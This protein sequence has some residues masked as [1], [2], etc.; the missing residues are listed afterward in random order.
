[1]WLV[2]TGPLPTSWGALAPGRRT[3]ECTTSAGPFSRPR[4]VPPEQPSSADPLLRLAAMSAP[5]TYRSVASLG[6]V[7]CYHAS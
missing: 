7:C 6:R 2:R 5:A 4:L 1:M 3:A